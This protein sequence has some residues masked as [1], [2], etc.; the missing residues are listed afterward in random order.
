MWDNNKHS[1][2]IIDARL[3]EIDLKRIFFFFLYRE[4]NTLWLS[5]LCNAINTQT[6]LLL[7]FTFICPEN[8]Q[9]YCRVEYQTT[10]AKARTVDKTKTAVEVFYSTFIIQQIGFAH[11][12]VRFNKKKMPLM[13]NWSLH[14]RTA[15]N[16]FDEWFLF[17]LCTESSTKIFWL[18]AQWIIIYR[19]AIFHRCAMIEG[20]KN[21]VAQFQFA[22]ERHLNQ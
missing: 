17:A 13:W 16:K 10:P 5:P 22:V 15:K 6:C 3:I 2:V 8:S 12:T 21:W 18:D 20:C 1:F 9:V 11:F 7:F 4:L 19:C 14:N